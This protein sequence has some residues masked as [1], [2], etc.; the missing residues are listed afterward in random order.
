MGVTIIKSLQE[1]RQF[2]GRQGYATLVYV[3]VNDWACTQMIAKCAEVMNE[4]PFIRFAYVD[5]TIAPHTIGGITCVGVPTV[6]FFRNGVPIADSVA[7]TD[8]AKLDHLLRG[9]RADGSA[10]AAIP[11]KKN[12]CASAPKPIMRYQITTPSPS[13]AQESGSGV[14]LRIL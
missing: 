9:F 1:M 14:R 7:G 5:D 12:P 13:R 2:I 11:E 8:F 3:R 4:Y 10:I 6:L